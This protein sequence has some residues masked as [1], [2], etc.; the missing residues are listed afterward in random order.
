MKQLFKTICFLGLV[1]V[2][3]AMFK[4]NETLEKI[5]ITA[6]LVSVYSYKVQQQLRK[7]HL[8]ILIQQSH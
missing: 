4:K 1:K 7:L 8:F 2:L 5:L 6:A 3:L